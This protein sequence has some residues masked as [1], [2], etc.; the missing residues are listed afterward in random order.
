MEY[1]KTNDAK[2]KRKNT[3]MCIFRICLDKN[4]VLNHNSATCV[5]KQTHCTWYV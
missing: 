3:G 1:A 5:F 4:K 2:L